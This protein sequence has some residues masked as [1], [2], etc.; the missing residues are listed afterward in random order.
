[1]NSPFLIGIG[2]GLV[3][4][5]LFA[6]T[7]TGS[8]LAMML[9]YITALPGFLAGLGWGTTA[10][11]TAA[12]TGTA[13][14]AVLL[15]PLAGLGYFLTLGLPIAILCHLALLARPGNKTGGDS[16]QAA[17]M[18]WYPPGRIIA[19]TA[20]MAGGVAALSVPLFGMDVETYR[21]NLQ[22]ILD[23][24]FLN[25][26]P[27]GTPPGMS[28]EQMG[29]VIELLIR[30]LPAASAIVWLAIMLLNMWT[31][32]KIAAASGRLIRP[33]PDLTM[34]SYPGPLALGF[35]AA[36]LGTFTPGILGIVATGFAG[37]F[38]VAYVLLGLVV[39]HVM[40]RQSPF[41]HIIIG[42]LYLGIFLFGWVALVVAMIGIGDPIFK[43]R[44]RTLG[45]NTN[46]PP[47][48]D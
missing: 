46:P 47:D 10:A 22:Q 7:M 23:K 38:L 37:A 43:L 21:A 4:A 26:L 13:L 36:L 28:K 30:A 29:P 41:R 12:V 6:S 1:M 27:G 40:A 14:T 9:F 19:W 18:E 45:K 44:E 25:Q 8:A 11:I 32:A 16:G 33:W 39:L 17:A 24:T 31:A 3:S 34:M 2:A 15:A 42:T 35:V 20:L 5:V 48:N